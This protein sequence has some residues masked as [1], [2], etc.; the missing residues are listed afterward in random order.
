MVPLPQNVFL[1]HPPSFL[2]LDQVFSACLPA[3]LACLMQRSLAMLNGWGI[4]LSLPEW[5]GSV[6][7]FAFCKKGAKM[8][9]YPKEI[10]LKKKRGGKKKEN[11]NQKLR[12]CI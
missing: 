4:S 7:F 8:Q 9:I 2:Q 11:N 12:I 5:E 3:C 1:S 6:L 10:A